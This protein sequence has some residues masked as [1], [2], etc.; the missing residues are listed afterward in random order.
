[1]NLTD[2][3][4]R[5]YLI[6]CASRP[7]RLERALAHLSA[8]GMA[9]ASKVIVYPA[10]IGGWTGYPADWRA[11]CGAWGCLQSHRRILEDVIHVRN[12]RGMMAL[13]STLILEDDVFFTDD[14]LPRLNAFMAAV[15]SD[16]G[17]IYL[18][19][20]HRRTPVPVPE[21]SG[22]MRASSV[23]RTHAYAVS[24]SA[25][26]KVYC[27]VS[28]MPDYHGRPVHI[29]HQLERAHRRGDWPVYCPARWIAGQ[30]AGRSDISGR[31]NPRK[32]WK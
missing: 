11:G 2:L 21:R 1:M 9:D 14:A 23:H 20:Q 12:A 24:R 3:F 7:D 5:V 15:P 25:V 31:T 18:G 4:S 10:V 16:W 22:V 27:H 6:N 8:S 30:D 19:G 29:D 28:Y 17:Q 32:L 13:D 26:T